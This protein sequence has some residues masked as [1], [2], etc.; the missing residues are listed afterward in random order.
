MIAL[1]KTGPG[2]VALT[3]RQPRALG[4]G[5]VRVR[6]A[7]AGVCGTDLH[8]AQD[9]YA[10]GPP[11]VMGHEISGTVVEVGAGVDHSWVGR[12]VACE[13]FFS[14]CE[15][16]TYCRDGHRNLC[17]RRRSLGSFEDGGFAPLV[18]L[19]ALNLH[20]LPDDLDTVAA[21]LCEP[22]ACVCHCLLDPPLVSPGAR[23]LV[24]GPG[25]MGLLSVQVSLAQGAEVT[26][27]GLTADVRRLD[28][29][30]ELGATTTTDIEDDAFDL[31]VECSGSAGGIVAALR[32]ATRGGRVV[33]V[34]LRG[35]SVD[36]PWDLILYKELQVSSGFASTPQSWRRAMALVASRQV[37]P[38]RLVTHVLP[39]VEWERAF[40]LVGSAEAIKVVI[41]PA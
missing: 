25:A 36:V 2:S 26:C 4:H 15:E 8:I 34:G 40:E 7:G 35:T 33:Q 37:D 39:L 5:L 1:T 17:A 28:V 27:A 18:V 3:D 11:V 20:A 23:V 31:V 32:A 16:C 29:A 24:I 10:S 30:R 21:T 9:E 13:S 41:D 38:S 19:P 22:L 6:V 14:A 12:R